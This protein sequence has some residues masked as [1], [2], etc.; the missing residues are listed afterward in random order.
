MIGVLVNMVVCM[1]V[2]ATGVSGFLTDGSTVSPQSRLDALEVM[3][4][5]EVRQRQ[6]LTQALNVASGRLS[7]LEQYQETCGRDIFMKLWVRMCYFS[8]FIGYAFVFNIYRRCRVKSL[9]L[10]FLKFY[11]RN[12]NC[13]LFFFVDFFCHNFTDLFKEDANKN[14]GVLRTFRCFEFIVS[15]NIVNQWYR[16]F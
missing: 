3:L 2:C 9:K 6:Q 5:E 14:V 15:Q 4:A 16:R 13:I 10:H 11:R 7:E 8:W 12:K 1:I